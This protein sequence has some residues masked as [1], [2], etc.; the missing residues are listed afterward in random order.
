AKADGFTKF[1]VVLTQQR[2]YVKKPTSGQAVFDAYFRRYPAAAE[3]LRQRH[4]NYNRTREEL[5]DLEASGQAYVF[6]PEQMT[7]A[8]GTKSVAQ[9]QAA[10]DLGAAQAQREVRAWRE[11]LGL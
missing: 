5:F 3:A 1:F 6:T 9:L 7:I 10:F 8:N 4:A 11:F 2:D